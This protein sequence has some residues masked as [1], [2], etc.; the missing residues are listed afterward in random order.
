M[1]V[2]SFVLLCEKLRSIFKV[3]KEMVNEL[4]VRKEDQDWQI[5]FML[6]V[7]GKCKNKTMINLL[8]FW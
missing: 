6:G 1:R 2:V 8:I 7:G 4:G 5:I 3:L